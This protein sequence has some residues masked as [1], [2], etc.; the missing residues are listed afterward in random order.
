[1][2]SLS[3]GILIHRILMLGSIIGLLMKTEENMGVVLLEKYL[4]WVSFEQNR[5]ILVNVILLPFSLP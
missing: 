2:K 5:T 4:L 1:M 3:Y